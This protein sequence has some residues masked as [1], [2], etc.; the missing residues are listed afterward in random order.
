[1]AGRLAHVYR[2]RIFAATSANSPADMRSGSCTGMP[3]IAS[4]HA[5]SI[6]ASD[7]GEVA[8]LES[9]LAKELP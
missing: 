9:R 7:F 5:G 8:A 6:A 4:A 2:S 3:C 1:M